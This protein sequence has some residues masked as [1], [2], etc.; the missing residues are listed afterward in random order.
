MCWAVN[1]MFTW[2]GPL[3]DRAFM[4]PPLATMS[5][6]INDA[7]SGAAVWRCRGKSVLV[8]HCAHSM[9]RGRRQDLTFL[10]SMA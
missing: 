10:H 7:S 8:L 1:Y 2:L 5:M 3:Q 4:T 6:V 9:S